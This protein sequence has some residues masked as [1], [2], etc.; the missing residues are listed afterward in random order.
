MVEKADTAIKIIT[1]DVVNDRYCDLDDHA[2][3]EDGRRL[4]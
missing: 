1:V 3:E 4:A 2:Q